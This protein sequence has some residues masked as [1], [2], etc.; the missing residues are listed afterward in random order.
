MTKKNFRI[1]DKVSFRGRV[2]GY[3]DFHLHE[4]KVLVRETT[5]LVRCYL[6]DALELAEPRQEEESAPDDEEEEPVP[7]CPTQAKLAEAI[8]ILDS[9]MARARNGSMLIRLHSLVSS[10][11]NDLTW[12]EAD[13]V[14][15]PIEDQL[16]GE[17]VRNPPF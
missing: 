9:L 4:N 11:L 3:I 7:T 17:L 14:A 16:V 8:D 10:A 1:G 13:V 12:D 6:T 5:G 15:I 2:I